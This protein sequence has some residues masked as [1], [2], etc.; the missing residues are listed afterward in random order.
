MRI[1]GRPRHRLVDGA[2]VDELGQPRDL[3]GGPLQRHEQVQQCLPI[4]AC[5]RFLERAREWPML[6]PAPGT[7]AHGVG[8]QEP[9]RVVVVT[10][11]LGQM[12]ADFADG[13]PR[14]VARAQPLGDGA[15]VRADLLGEGV[16]DVGPARRHPVGVDVLA[17]VHGRHGGREPRALVRRAVDLHALTPLLEV[18]HRAQAGHEG[19]ADVPE[20]CEGGDERGVEL[21]G[22]EVE[23]GVTGAAREGPQDT[24]ARRDGETVSGV[25]VGYRVREQ[26]AGGQDRHA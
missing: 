3:L 6:H 15:S 10:A 5:G 4:A 2:G 9:E 12:Q 11:V 13:V 21:G 18:G 26:R 7:R 16:V 8:R 17:A 25:V 22:A 1:L 24:R 19:A 20:I 23:Q 14:R